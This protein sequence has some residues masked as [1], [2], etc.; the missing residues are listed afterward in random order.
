MGYLTPLS[1]T[2]E[3]SDQKTAKLDQVN[4]SSYCC[5]GKNEEYS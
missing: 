3:I 5:L 1:A 4:G 2:L